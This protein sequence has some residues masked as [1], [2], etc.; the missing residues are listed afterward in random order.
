MSSVGNKLHFMFYPTNNKY[1]KKLFWQYKFADSPVE[2]DP[3]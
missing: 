2:I 3:S 1:I